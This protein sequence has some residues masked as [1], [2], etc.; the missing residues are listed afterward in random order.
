MKGTRPGRT[1]QNPSI[2]RK[3]PDNMLVKRIAAYLERQGDELESA[4]DLIFG[5]IPE[6]V[7]L[8]A[9]ERVQIE[10]R[11]LLREGFS[12]AEIRS[13]VIEFSIDPNALTIPG[14]VANPFRFSQSISYLAVF[15]TGI[16]LDSIE[17]LTVL[18]GE[19]AARGKKFLDG[20]KPGTG[21]PIRKEVAKLLA[22]DP[23]LRNPELWKAVKEN[24]PRGWEAGKLAK[25]G[26]YVEAHPEKM[27]YR[28]FCN[29]CGEERKKL[30]EKIT[31]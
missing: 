3:T 22:N 6:W 27:F 26:E 16:S 24:L 28:R 8:L 19:L 20:R 25:Y 9:R 14:T 7:P 2:A 21:G 13:R 10:V 5:S 29:V 31:G 1:P 11:E 30:R 15:Q 4:L 12:A 18:S 17:G 23:T